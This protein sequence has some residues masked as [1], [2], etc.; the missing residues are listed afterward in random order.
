LEPDRRKYAFMVVERF[1]KLN[2]KFKHIVVN[3][4]EAWK[5]VFPFYLRGLYEYDQL[6]LP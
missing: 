4:K 2:I 5:A 1:K 3:I 6:Y